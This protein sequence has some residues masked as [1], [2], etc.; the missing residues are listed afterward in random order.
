MIVNDMDPES[1]QLR[2]VQ[3]EHSGGLCNCWGVKD[4]SLNGMPLHRFVFSQLARMLLYTILPSI[5]SEAACDSV[6][7]TSITNDSCSV[8]FCGGSAS[9]PRGVVFPPVI[10][11]SGTVLNCSDVINGSAVTDDKGPP[12]TT[13]SDNEP[14]M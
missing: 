7:Y 9:V 4:F 8:Q 12:P 11:S 5:C 1:V 10:L 14:K 13:C 6:Q 2:I 3:P